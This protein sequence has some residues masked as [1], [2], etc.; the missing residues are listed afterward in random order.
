MLDERQALA[1]SSVAG[2]RWLVAQRSEARTSS[3]KSCGCSQAAKVAPLFDLVEVDEVGVS[4]L[5]PALRRLILLAGK[6]AHRHR[7]G[8]SLNVDEAALVFPVEAR[9]GDPGVREPV[10][11][12]VVEYR[13]ACWPRASGCSRDSSR[14][15]AAAR[16]RSCGS[17]SSNC[18]ASWQP[19]SRCGRLEA[20]GGRGIA[21]QGHAGRRSIRNRREERRVRGR[22]S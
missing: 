15:S 14:W 3:E 1:D 17:V 20:T 5:R 4:L 7:N 10:E 13:S 8:D 19:T 16:R 11:R 22:G 2:N 9:G 6:D 12:E 21:A 18:A